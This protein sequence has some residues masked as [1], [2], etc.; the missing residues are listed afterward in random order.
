MFVDCAN[1]LPEGIVSTDVCVIGSGPAGLVVARALIESGRSV[2]IIERG[3]DVA[4]TPNRDVSFKFRRY[5]GINTGIAFGYGGT[6]VLWGGQL[7]PMLESELAALGVPWN[8]QEFADDLASGYRQIESWVGVSPSPYDISLLKQAG[9]VADQLDWGAFRPLFSKWIPFRRRNLGAAWMTALRDSGRVQVL[10]NL[11]PAEWRFAGDSDRRDISTVMCRNPAGKS[12]EI[13]AKRF[14]IAAGAL[15]SPLILQQ[16]LGNGLAEALG[17]GR[18]LHDHL[19]L[20]IA[21]ITG[22]DRKAF[23]RY[24]SAFFT[25]TTMRSLRLC[26]LDSDAQERRANLAYCHFVIEAPADSG[27]ALVRDLLRGLQAKNYASAFRALTKLP[28]ASGDILRMAWRRYAGQRLGISKGSRIFINVDFV[29][30]PADDNRIRK[31]ET[32]PD[33]IEVAW[34]IHEDLQGLIERTTQ[35]L[36]QFWRANGLESVGTL[37]PFDFGGGHEKAFDNLYDI[38]HPAGTCAV[39]RVVDSDLRIAGVGNGYVVGSA[40][41]PK[42]GRSNP[43]LTIMALGLRLARHIAATFEHGHTRGSVE[44]RQ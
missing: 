17:V 19:S 35:A 39:G 4:R 2:A 27:F 34:D 9:H 41:M 6:G 20:R 29:Q 40:V 12:V 11:M 28:R 8:T 1:A 25:A 5:E 31:N 36:M 23:E 32:V 44:T 18:A 22:Y 10:L 42:L 43:T 24:F 15:E 13:R 21:E 3:G 38:Y 33:G 14:V 7:L 37:Q 26:L 16:M 30:T